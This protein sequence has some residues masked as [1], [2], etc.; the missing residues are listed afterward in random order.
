MSY[1]NV[2]EV[3]HLKKHFPGFDLR[4]VSFHLPKGKIV[5]FIGKNGAGKSTTIN[6]LLQFVHADGG[7]VSFFG[8]D[9]KTHAKKIKEKIGFVSAGL[10]YYQ[11]VKIK[12]IT[13]VVKRFYGNWSDETYRFYMDKF[14]I[15][16]DKTPKQLSNGMKI[17]YTLALALSYDAELFIL[18]EP[19]S[20]LDPVSREEILEIF[21]DL[22]KGGKTI[23]F[24]THITPDLDK[25]ADRVIY[26]RDGVIQFNDT[27]ENIMAKYRL[28]TYDPSH[29]N[30]R[31]Q[32]CIIG[33]R[34]SR[35]GY[36]ALIKSENESLFE[37][38]TEK[39]TLN[40]IFVHLEKEAV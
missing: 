6:S 4:D 24:S 30:A 31:Q 18:D 13:S 15:S 38:M 3:K 36:N 16:E 27:Y 12:K 40:E 17:K 34:R 23:F 20:G 35:R 29:L 33:E 2:L 10:T 11:S 37:G 26:L 22:V 32:A 28:V 14:K 19:T 7:E 39:A 25:C 9:P 8:M 1:E 21:L 5:G